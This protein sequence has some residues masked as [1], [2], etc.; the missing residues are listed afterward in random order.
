M[1]VTLSILHDLVLLHL[2]I[3]VSPDFTIF[4]THS[5]RCGFAFMSVL[6]LLLV[7]VAMYYFKIQGCSIPFQCPTRRSN[8][9]EHA[10]HRR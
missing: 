4:P 7:L 8:G 5:L 9:F 1:C 6:V 3:D 2:E 10:E